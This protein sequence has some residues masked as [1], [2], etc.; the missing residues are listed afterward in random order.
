M[1]ILKELNINVGDKI[2]PKDGFGN[3]ILVMAIADGYV[4]ARRKGCMAFCKTEL[5]FVLFLKERHAI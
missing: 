2:Y 1:S 5:D 3:Y 4:M